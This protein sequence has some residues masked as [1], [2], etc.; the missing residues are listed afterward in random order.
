MTDDLRQQ[1]ADAL[2]GKAYPVDVAGAAAALEPVVRTWA[3]Q[4]LR[5]LAGGVRSALTDDTPPDVRDALTVMAVA[6]EARADAL[7][8]PGA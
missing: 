1:L 5:D 4:Q 3:A 2:R 8:E 7:G 6:T